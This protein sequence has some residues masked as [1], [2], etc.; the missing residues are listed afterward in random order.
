MADINGEVAPWLQKSWGPTDH[1]ADNLLPWLKFGY[2]A[3]QQKAKLPLEIQGMAL[4][5]QA[6]QAAIEHQGIINELQGQQLASYNSELPRFQQ[7]VKD[8][9]GD[10][11][12]IMNRIE[13]FNS[14]VLQNQWLQLQKQA[15]STTLGTAHNEQVVND[16]RSAADLVKKGMPPP[17]MNPDGTVNRESLAET[18]QAYADHQAQIAAA[19]TAWHYDAEGNP[20]ALDVAQTRAN[21]MMEAAKIRANAVPGQG[22]TPEVKIIEGN[23]FLINPKNGHWEHLEKHQTKSEFVE[24]HALKWAMDNMMTPEDSVKAL[25]DVYDK[26]IAPLSAPPNPVPTPKSTGRVRVKSPDGKI[27][28]IPAD[29]LDEAKAKGYSPLP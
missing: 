25:G 23:K 19:R 24:K 20:V 13:S 8:T 9:G 4:R 22:V 28:S 7:V 10:P 18:A 14:P 29:Q 17:S 26:T 3:A 15:A 21:A 11:I 6:Q 5:N 1:S 16:I 2:E 12:S 27:G